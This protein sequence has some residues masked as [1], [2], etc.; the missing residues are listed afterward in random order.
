MIPV[1]IISGLSW[2]LSWS[3]ERPKFEPWV[4]KIPWRRKWQPTPVLLLGEFHGQRSLVGDSPWGH[5]E[6]DII[7]IF[8]KCPLKICTSLYH[9]AHQQYQN[10]MLH[11]YI[12]LL[13][14]LFLMQRQSS[15]QIKIAK[16]RKRKK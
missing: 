7:D 15:K 6:S 13:H 3:C 12:F 5:K 10:Y 4:G 1:Y 11:I 2:W 14:L 16:K 9:G 8:S